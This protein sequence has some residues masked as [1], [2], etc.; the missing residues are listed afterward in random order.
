[1]SDR[2]LFRIRSNVHVVESRQAS[3]HKHVSICVDVAKADKEW[4]YIAASV[5]IGTN[6][7]IAQ[8]NIGS[9]LIANF[10]FHFEKMLESCQ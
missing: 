7:V 5:R 4:D 3:E 1:M 8:S 2:W 6:K 10:I 9:G